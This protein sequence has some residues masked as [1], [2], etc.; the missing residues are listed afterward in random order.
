MVLLD[1]NP[2]DNICNTQA[3]CLV[4]TGSWTFDPKELRP[5]APTDPVE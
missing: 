3:I 1:A 2:P 5:T 4:V